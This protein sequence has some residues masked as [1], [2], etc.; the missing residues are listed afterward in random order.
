MRAIGMRGDFA[1]DDSFDVD[2]AD[3][4]AGRDRFDFIEAKPQRSKHRNN[5]VRSPYLTAVARAVPRR[6]VTCVTPQAVRVPGW[7]VIASE[8]RD[9]A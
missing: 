9:C 4:H 8:R 1:A 2:K 6:V 3:L 7:R 5:A